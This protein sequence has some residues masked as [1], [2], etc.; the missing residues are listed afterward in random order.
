[1]MPVSRPHPQGR[2]DVEASVYVA[3]GMTTTS[4]SQVRRTPITG[5][6]RSSARCLGHDFDMSSTLKGMQ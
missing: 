6:S 1:M 4:P 3:Q 2:R 5:G